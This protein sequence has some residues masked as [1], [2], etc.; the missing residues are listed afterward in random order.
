M[1]RHYFWHFSM[2]NIVGSHGCSKY[3]NKF[4]RQNLKDRK[5]PLLMLF[6]IYQNNKVK[7]A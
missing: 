3:V 6:L 5:N 7:D 4:K 1:L 2:C